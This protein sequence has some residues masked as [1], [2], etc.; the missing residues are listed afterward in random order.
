MEQFFAQLWDKI[1]A[2]IDLIIVGIVLVSGFFQSQYLPSWRIVKNDS[3]N[4]ALKTL[5]VSFIA[6]SIY[7]FL[8]K[9]PGKGDNWAKYFMSY[10]LATSLYQ[11]GIKYIMN[12]I[13]NKLPS[14]KPPETKP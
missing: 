12:W 8:S 10:F 9:D 3:Q 13:G 2:S 14:A 1:S 11:F 4:G 7:L 6:C 5:I